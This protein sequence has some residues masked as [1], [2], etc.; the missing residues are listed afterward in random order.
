LSDQDDLASRLNRETRESWDTNAAFW[1]EKMGEGN[2]FQRVLVGPAA[3]RLLTLQPG[4]VV[5]EI[6][7]GNGQFARRMAS[8]GAQVIACDFS[9]NML[10]RAA[11]HA[12]N[13]AGRI[14]YRLIDACF[15]A[16]FI[17]DGREEPAFGPEDETA[18]PI[19]WINFKEFPPI[20]AA[21]VMLL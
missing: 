5:L 2:A 11:A 20:L 17:L 4:E 3:E 7:C 21:R 6:A 10:E 9:S 18:Q 1:D 19:S 8:L 16:G 12:T 15:Q 13:Y 14:E